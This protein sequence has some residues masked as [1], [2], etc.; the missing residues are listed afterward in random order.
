MRI[1]NSHFCSIRKKSVEKTVPSQ[2]TIRALTEE[3]K[4]KYINIKPFNKKVYNDF[5]GHVTAHRRR[6]I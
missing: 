4:T 1:D 5:M 3:E 2:C 6:C